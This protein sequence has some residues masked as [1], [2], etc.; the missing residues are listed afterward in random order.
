AYTAVDQ[1]EKERDIPWS[2]NSTAP[3]ILAQEALSSGAVLIHY[4]TDFVFDGSKKESYKE[5]DSPNPIS[6]YGESKLG[7][8]REITKV[9]GEYYIFRTSWLYSTRRDCFVTKVLKWARTNEIM[10]IVA[11]QTGS[12]TWS[13]TLADATA[14]ALMVMK[15]SGQTWRKEKAGVYHLAGNGSVSRYE[16]AKSILEFDPRGEEQVVVELQKTKSEE[17]KI[18]ALRPEYSALDCSLFQETFDTFYADW[19]T[20]LALALSK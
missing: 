16:W 13:R 5:D 1:A 18:S 15:S 10:K 14:Q 19:Q 17:F 4:S 7:G 6:V 12:P 20:T 9:G 11:D 8:E 2:I 3:G